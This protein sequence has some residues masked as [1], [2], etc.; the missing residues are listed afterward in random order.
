MNTFGKRIY[1][2]VHYEV[3]FIEIF[4]TL[5]SG[6]LDWTSRWAFCR[7]TILK[8]QKKTEKFSL[9]WTTIIMIVSVTDQK[10]S[11]AKIG[12][13]YQ[14]FR[15][16]SKIILNELR[17]LQRIFPARNFAEFS[18]K[19]GITS[20]LFPIHLCSLSKNIRIEIFFLNNQQLIHCHNRW[21]SIKIRMDFNKMISMQFWWFLLFVRFFF[22]F[23]WILKF[24]NLY[25][26]K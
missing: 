18:L 10:C 11:C 9:I 8:L 26:W 24:I 15:N 7:I 13:P 4:W 25:K 2:M 1:A 22:Y 20:K 5:V 23:S 6:R 14:L 16:L 21:N 17:I 19:F 3:Y 12:L